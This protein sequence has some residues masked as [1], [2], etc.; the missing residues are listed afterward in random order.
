MKEIERRR[1]IGAANK[2]KVPWTKGRKLSKEHKELIKQRT[3]EALRDPKVRQKMLG[4]RQ[5][6]SLTPFI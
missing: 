4:H 2:G 3:T 5:L 6:H 1:K